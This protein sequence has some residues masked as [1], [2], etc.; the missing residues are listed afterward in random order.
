MRLLLRVLRGVLLTILSLVAG[1][2]A[3]L[4]VAPPDL[5]RVGTGAVLEAGLERVLAAQRIAGGKGSAA[6]LD[7][8]LPLRACSGCHLLLLL[9]VGYR[10]RTGSRFRVSLTGGR[11]RP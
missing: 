9:L 3:W 2:I 4:A 11:A 10:Y 5:L 7:C 6:F 1:A 8:A